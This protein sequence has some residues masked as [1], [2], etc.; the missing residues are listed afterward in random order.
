MRLRLAE[1]G[2][3]DKSSVRRLHQIHDER[4]VR[5][6]SSCDRTAN[7]VTGTSR[8]HLRLRASAHTNARSAR[9]ALITCFS[10]SVRTAA[11]ASC[12]GQSAPR[13][14][15]GPGFASRSGR[16]RPSACFCRTR[17]KTS[18]RTPNA[19]GT[20]R[21]RIA[22]PATKAWFEGDR[23]RPLPLRGGE[24]HHLRPLVGI[25]HPELTEFRG[26]EHDRPPAHLGEA[27]RDARIGEAGVDLAVE[28][29]DDRRRRA[30]GNAD[31]GPAAYLVAWHGLA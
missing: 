29:G 21:P 10:T 4:S 11:E 20:L 26:G 1:F 19:L 3:C 18:R 12:P 13:P 24:L 7:A 31:A 8:P 2:V 16:L 22:D 9:I 14:N 23:P 6:H 5:W 30:G 28:R 25:A 15:G 17:V 27:R